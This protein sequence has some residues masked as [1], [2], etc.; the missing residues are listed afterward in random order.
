MLFRE[1]DSINDVEKY[2][3]ARLLVP[4]EKAVKLQKDEYFVADLI[5][6]QVV[7]EDGEPFGRLKN[8]LETGAND[9]YVV[10]TAEGREVL[11]PAIKECVL[12]VD[13]EKGVITVHIM[14]GLLD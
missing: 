12:Q 3:G 8:V 5:G 11:L 2:K 7:T 10:E 4:R 6:M 14:D 1:Y 9:V 13:M